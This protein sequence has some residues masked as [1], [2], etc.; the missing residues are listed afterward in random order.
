M[1]YVDNCVYICWGGRHLQVPYIVYNS[2][3]HIENH[4]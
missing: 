3:G 4:L 1:L 2:P